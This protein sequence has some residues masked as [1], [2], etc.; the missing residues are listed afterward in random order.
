MRGANLGSLQSK[1]RKVENGIS[2]EENRQHASFSRRTWTF[3]GHSATARPPIDPKSLP[4][5]QKKFAPHCQQFFL[6]RPFFKFPQTLEKGAVMAKTEISALQRA[7]STGRRSRRNPK[8][9]PFD[10]HSDSRHFHVF[11]GH[12]TNFP[13][14]IIQKIQKM[15]SVK[16]RT[17]RTSL[18]PCSI[19]HREPSQIHHP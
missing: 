4:S 5:A 7:I 19:R 13:K 16:Y 14:P 8:V 15:F 1:N 17:K 10:P 9:L 6:V 3:P 18:N 12:V 2:S 11:G